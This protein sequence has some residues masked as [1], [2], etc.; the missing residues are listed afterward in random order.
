MLPKLDLKYI[1]ILVI[2]STLIVT[3]IKSFRLYDDDDQRDIT[4]V[5]SG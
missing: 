1:F 4:M 5:D 2:V 3:A